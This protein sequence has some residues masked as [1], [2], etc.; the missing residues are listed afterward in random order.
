MMKK[1]LLFSFIFLLGTFSIAFSQKMAVSGKVSDAKGEPLVGASL[2]EKGT[3]NGTLSDAD[4]NYTLN[5]DKNATIVASFVGYV[6]QDI[7]VAGNAK[8]D[9]TLQEGSAL[10]EV[11]V[12]A[13]GISREKKSLGYAA[14]ELKGS[15]ITAAPEVSPINNLAGQVAG[16]TLTRGT[17][18]HFLRK[19]DAESPQ[20]ENKTE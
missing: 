18:G 10:N 20:K 12:T 14:Q 9:I 4:G 13:L 19:G 15:D 1:R 5:V 8:L 3:S 17:Y 7:A 2:V 6:L 11:V 16:L